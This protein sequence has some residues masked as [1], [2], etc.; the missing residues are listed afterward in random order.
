AKTFGPTDGSL[1]PQRM[2]VNCGV[3]RRRIFEH[4]ISDR[5][6]REPQTPAFPCH[7]T[8]IRHTTQ[9]P[10]QSRSVSRARAAP[11]HTRRAVARALAF[12]S[13]PFGPG[14]LRATASPS[15]RYERR[16][17]FWK[18]ALLAIQAKT[19]LSWPIWAPAAS[20]AR[21]VQARRLGDLL[22]TLGGFNPLTALDHLA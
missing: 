4:S 12:G 20:R 8:L 11:S 15:S 14:S 7:V 1:S 2:R 18:H 13:Q 22:H 17:G 16:A 3:S 21:E 10:T 6:A 9:R 19:L 5:T